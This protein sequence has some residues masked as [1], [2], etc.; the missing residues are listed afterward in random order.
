MTLVYRKLIM[1]LTEKYDDDIPNY[2][3]LPEI[4]KDV[5]WLGS[6]IVENEKVIIQSGTGLDVTSSLRYAKDI[7]EEA[8]KYINQIDTL[9]FGP[10]GTSISNK[11]SEY[12]NKNPE[13]R[14]GFAGEKHLVLPTN[15]GLTRANYAGPN[16]NLNTRL[17]R[18]DKGVDGPN[19]IDEAAKKHDIAYATANNY[20]D[21]RRADNEFIDDVK[22]SS[23]GP[24]MK[25]A[26]ISAIKLKQIG[27]DAG[28]LDN[29]RYLTKEQ[30]EKFG[31][32]GNESK[33]T[34]KIV[35]D[36]RTNTKLYPAQ[37]LEKI[38]KNK[39]KIKK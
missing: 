13:W 26:V 21:I 19:G 28:L 22:N 17:E 24:M 37:I 3:Q 14:P 11:L 10:I 33:H 34:F 20:D 39:K 25:K 18:G 8:P 30:K 4:D 16:T 2:G 1:M 23:Q 12:Y 35:K 6:N 32:K 29:Q 31:G 7:L 27:E 15:F 38:L 5:P 36:N 9:A